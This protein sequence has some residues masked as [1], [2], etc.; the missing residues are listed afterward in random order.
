MKR[1]KFTSQKSRAQAIVEFA[2]VLP[3]LLLVVYGL[4][5]TGRLLFI[6]SSV[7]NA[8]R[9]A[10][11]YGSTSGIDPT[12]GVPRYQACDGI[13][14]AAQAAD[15][16]NAFDDGDIVIA[17]A[18]GPTD[19][20]PNDDPSTPF[21]ENNWE[22]A[23][24]NGNVDT[25]AKPSQGDRVTVRVAADYNPIV[26]LLP[27]IKPR[28]ITADSARTLLLEVSIQPPKEITTTLITSDAPDPSAPG[29][30]VEV[31]VTVTANTTPTGTVEITGA[32]QNCTITLAGSGGAS[33]GS[34]FVSFNSIGEKT[35]TATYTG[36]SK[37]DPSSDTESH[38]V[39]GPTT[40]TLTTSPNPS[41]INTQ[42]TLSVTVTS[43]YGTPTGTVTITEGSNTLC[44]I[45][46]SNG[47][48]SCAVTFTSDGD[49][50]LTAS[51][52]GDSNFFDSSGTKVH[53]VI[54]PGQTTTTITT[55]PSPSIVGQSV[56]ITVNVTS[57]S[58]P[59]GTV[60][61]TIGGT[62]VCTFRLSGG[63]GTCSTTFNTV[64]NRT[65][66]ATYTPD[67]SS[68]L[69]SS[70]SVNHAVQLPP[71][72]TTLTTTNTPPYLVGQTINLTVTV[73]NA[74]G[75]STVTPTGTVTI[76]GQSSGCTTPITLN[77]SGS[78]TCTVTFST[79]GSKTLT[80]T[81]SGD[82]GHAASTGTLTLNVT[83]SA[84]SGCNTVT[85]GLL[86]QTGGAMTVTINN[87]L[88]EFLQIA[89]VTVTWN[90]DKGH[91][92]GSDKTLRL[93]SASLGSVFWTGNELGPTYTIT[94]SS[95]I[96]IPPGSSTLAFNFHQVFDR[97]DDTEQ[98]TIN[99]STPGCEGVVLFQNQ[100]E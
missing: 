93:Q 42:A 37:H 1:L 7:N 55:S 18:H 88:T 86:R 70:G 89:N 85:L 31:S 43:A 52:S 72:I 100:H 19:P 22:Y 28:T 4:I 12:Y 53:K 14:A 45:T 71:T 24:C 25:T 3:I 95:P 48:G 21:K 63:T 9:Q 81:Y 87:P 82:S 90:H 69:G 39:K 13:R 8:A 29:Q 65:I 56:T 17:Y 36:D 6:Y 75:G 11:R 57:T 51:Y 27:M 73:S 62:P 15:F 38:N 84:V 54:L 26:P 2:I 23:I 10:A 44:T 66:T 47:A 68:F 74:P 34:C 46:L 50:L 80:A 5:E 61:V 98:V 32:D 41:L 92:T 59:T 40:T 91:Q 97:W 76:S 83:T 77:A 79:P 16:L 99:L 94:P 96:F 33:S 58:T 35:I 64:G 49:K 30:S 67:S 20:R 60:T 78:G